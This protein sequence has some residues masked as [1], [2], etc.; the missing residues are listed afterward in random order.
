MKYIFFDVD[1][2]IIDN[3]VGIYAG[4]DYAINKLNLRQVTPEEKRSFIGPP[5]LDNFARLFA[6]DPEESQRAVDVYREYYFDKGYLE[7]RVYPGVEELLKQLDKEGYELY[8]ASSKGEIM[9]RKI[10]EDAGISKYFKNICGATLDGTR[11]T[12]EDVL[13]YAIGDRDKAQSLI[14][15]DRDHDVIGAKAVGIKSIGITWGGFSEREEL[16]QAGADQIVDLPEEILP[17]ILLLNHDA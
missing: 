11:A 13:N 2:T 14:I 7:Y 16:E 6:M 12:K 9:V 17:A 15:G 5:L 10:L 4:L 1:G 3:S 8:T